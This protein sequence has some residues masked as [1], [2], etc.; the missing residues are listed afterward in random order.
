MYGEAM[1]T[2]KY[3]KVFSM[4]YHTYTYIIGER[5]ILDP[6]IICLSPG[7]TL[8][9]IQLHIPTDNQQDFKKLLLRMTHRA[10]MRCNHFCQ[11]L[12][13]GEHGFLVINNNFLKLNLFSKIHSAPTGQQKNRNLILS[14]KSTN[15]VY[16]PVSLLTICPLLINEVITHFECIVFRFFSLCGLLKRSWLFSLQ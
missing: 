5:P 14:A 3:P 2:E 1:L 7:N 9:R 8:I 16:Q 4:E 12:L 11:F 15:F 13:Y 6:R 10:C